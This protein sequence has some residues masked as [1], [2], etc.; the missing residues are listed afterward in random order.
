MRKKKVLLFAFSIFFNPI[1]KPN[2]VIDR[3]SPS[4]NSGT[5]ALNEEYSNRTPEKIVVELVL[6]SLKR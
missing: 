3:S 1:E 6:K 5:S 4:I 2:E